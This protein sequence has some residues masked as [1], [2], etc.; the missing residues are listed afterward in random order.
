MDWDENWKV[1]LMALIF[2]TGDNLEDFEDMTDN[3][4]LPSAQEVNL[5]DFMH[6]LG[7]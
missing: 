7:V 5:E 1:G 6:K 2:I 4:W 3:A